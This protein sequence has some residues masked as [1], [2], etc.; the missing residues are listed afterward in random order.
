[1]CDEDILLVKISPINNQYYSMYEQ[2]RKNTKNAYFHYEG[3]LVTLWTI[4]LYNNIK[5]ENKKFTKVKICEI[6]MRY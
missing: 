3:F 6:K 5:Q 1:M 4:Q 2:N